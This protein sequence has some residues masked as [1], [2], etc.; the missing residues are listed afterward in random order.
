MRALRL[1]ALALLFAVPLGLL[2]DGPQVGEE[3][4][5][6]DARDWLNTEEGQEVDVEEQ[7]GKVLVIEF[8]GTWCPPCRAVIPHMKELYKR[9]SKTGKFEVVAVHSVRGGDKQ[10]V[11]DFIVENEMPY[12]VCIDAGSAARDYGI[13][14]YPTALVVGPDG[15]VVYRGHPAAEEFEAAIDNQMLEILLGAQ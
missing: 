11:H 14:G 5:E 3:L 1:C 8:W 6:L 2:A 9:Y 10:A 12:P 15:R 13:E 4:V 7:D